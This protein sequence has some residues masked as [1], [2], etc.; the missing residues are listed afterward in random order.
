MTKS[1][2]HALAELGARVR[3][4]E[5]LIERALIV[6]AFPNLDASVPPTNNSARPGGLRGRAYSSRRRAPMTAAQRAAISQR[7][8][9]YW[10][11]RGRS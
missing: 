8:K 6:K 9:Q 11:S 4:Q 5:L 7:M 3:L 10:R 2:L 1:T